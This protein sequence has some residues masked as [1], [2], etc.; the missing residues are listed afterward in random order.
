ME[1][2]NKE[3]NTIMEL[4]TTKVKEMNEPTHDKDIKFQQGYIAGLRDVLS[5]F[6]DT[7][8]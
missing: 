1:S 8:K 3:A 2:K 4:I 5:L 6:N 7:N